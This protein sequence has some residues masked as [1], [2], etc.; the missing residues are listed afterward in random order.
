MNVSAKF[1][2]RTVGEALH[3]FLGDLSFA[4]VPQTNGPS[5]FFVFHT[6]MDDAT[7]YIH[8]AVDA[9]N[10]VAKPIPDE[11]VVRLKPGV[12]TLRTGPKSARR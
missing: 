5:K 10:H 2:E 6:S 9:S 11:L 8:P 7:L 4:L 3:L 12:G 1:K